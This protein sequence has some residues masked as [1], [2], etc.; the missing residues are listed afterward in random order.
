MKRIHDTANKTIFYLLA[1]AL[2]LTTLLSS[3]AVEKNDQILKNSRPDTLAKQV[4]YGTIKNTLRWKKIDRDGL[5]F[6]QYIDNN[7]RLPKKKRDSAA[8]VNY[9]VETSFAQLGRREFRQWDLVVVRGVLFQVN[10]PK[11]AEPTK[12]LF[13]GQIKIELLGMIFLLLGIYFF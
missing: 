13:P 12:L 3:C 5:L 9:F 10:L 2:W 7:F 1:T 4:N 6:D 8:I 11:S